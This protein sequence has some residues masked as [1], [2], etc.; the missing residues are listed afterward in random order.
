MS[1]L[2]SHSP[3]QS[4]KP[5][6]LAHMPSALHH[7]GGAEHGF[8]EKLG[9]AVTLG[10]LTA[11]HAVIAEGEQHHVV[12]KNVGTMLDI[13]W[14]PG[15]NT[16]AERLGLSAAINNAVQMAK[17]YNEIGDMLT[18]AANTLPRGAARDDLRRQV[19]SLVAPMLDMFG[20]LPP[21][22]KEKA[23]ALVAHLTAL[24]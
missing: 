13:I 15:K 22:R 23:E 24:L 10:D 6:G 7:T 21:G 16:H 4:Q 17:G 9:H 12:P 19:P 1:W 14:E 11:I 5:H 18:E 2:E 20:T 3:Q 8:R